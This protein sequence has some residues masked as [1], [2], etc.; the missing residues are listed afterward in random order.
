MAS[1]N[2]SPYQRSEHQT[3]AN[4]M[5]WTIL[6][7]GGNYN[8]RIAYFDLQAGVKNT[9]KLMPAPDKHT[10]ILHMDGIVIT[11]NPEAFEPR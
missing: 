10:R 6:A 8:L 7:P 2:G 1:V 5:V 3:N 11:D 4:Y 9:L